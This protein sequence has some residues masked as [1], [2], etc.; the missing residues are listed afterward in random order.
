MKAINIVWDVDCKEDL[1]RLPKELE[2]PGWIDKD[3]FDAISDYLSDAT[4]FCHKGYLLDPELPEVVGVAVYKDALGYYDEEDN[5]AEVLLPKRWLEDALKAEGQLPYEQWSNEYTADHT[6]GL[7]AKALEEKVIQGCSGIDVLTDGAKVEWHH[8]LYE[9]VGISDGLVYI[10][11]VNNDDHAE[12][13]IERFV[14]DAELVSEAQISRSSLDAQIA[15]AAAVKDIS[16]GGKN[17]PERDY[18]RD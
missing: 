16:S 3:D 10:Q 11:S 13:A 6:D 9:V 7:V 8:N 2:I 1:D 4:G 14:K 5:L 15:S 17:D 18:E 12:I